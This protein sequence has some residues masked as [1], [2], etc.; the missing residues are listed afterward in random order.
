MMRSSRSKSSAF[1]GATSRVAAA[2]VACAV[3][4][5]AC[6]AVL[7]TQPDPRG[8]TCD[9]LTSIEGTLRTDFEYGLTLENRGQKIEVIWPHG[10]STA[11]NAEGKVLLLDSAGQVIAQEG[12]SVV[13]SATRQEDGLN[14]VCDPPEL[15]IVQATT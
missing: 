11:R 2:V 3:A 6:N 5:A 14:Y 12:D 13:L 1:R 7:R 15:R 9:L 4:L 10:F 8:R